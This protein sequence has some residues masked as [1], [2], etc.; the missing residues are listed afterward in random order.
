MADKRYKGVRVA[1]NSHMAELME[2]VAKTEG[3]E[4]KAAQK[5]LT[6]HWDAVEAEFRKYFPSG[7]PGARKHKEA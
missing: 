5:A 7:L 6:K 1:S 4:K 2:T 3:E